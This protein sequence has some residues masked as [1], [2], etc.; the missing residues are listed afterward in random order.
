[1]PGVFL[2]DAQG[3]GPIERLTETS[4]P[5]HSPYAWTPDGRTLLLAIFRGFN[6]QAIARVT[7][8]STEVEV[9]LDGDF[10]QLDPQVS[11]DGRWMAYQ[12]DESGGFEIYVRPYPNVRA[13]RWQVSRRGGMSPRWNANGR[14]LFFFDGGGLTAVPVTTSGTFAAGA[15]RRL[16]PLLP[17]MGSL[18]TDY[19]VAADG[20]RFLFIL[21]EAGPP[22]PRAA[23]VWALNWLNTLE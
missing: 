8:P 17:T 19:E 15:P 4:W 3:A 13:G 1:M 21:P 12:S 14:E 2:R 7:P 22:P 23:V 6:S 10:A 20:R 18:G 11:P 16:F 9:L 5:I